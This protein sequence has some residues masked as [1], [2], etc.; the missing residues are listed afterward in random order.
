MI[1]ILADSSFLYLNP[2]STH[3]EV[4]GFANR[5]QEWSRASNSLDFNLVVSKK[6]NN[7][8]ADIEY[9]PD[10][11]SIS[12]CLAKYSIEYIDRRDL[13]KIITTLL[14]NNLLEDVIETNDYLADDHTCSVPANLISLGESQKSFICDCMRLLTL[15]E[16]ATNRNRRWCYFLQVPHLSL[17]QKIAHES[18]FTIIDSDNQILTSIPLPSRL[19]S[20]TIF[21]SELNNY[22][23]SIPI[24]I[25][26]QTP[27][28]LRVAT[29]IYIL[30]HYQYSLAEVESLPFTF[31]KKFFASLENNSVFLNKTERIEQILKTLSETILGQN[32]SKRHALREGSGPEDP[33]VVKNGEKAWRR[34][35]DY[36]FHLH[37]W[38][39]DGKIRFAKIG[40][41]NEFD[42]PY[43]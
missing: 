6:I 29:M 36:E 21:L 24:E 12:A 22:L 17:P 41:H 31:G 2:S 11:P 30:T 32:L 40:T 3:S 15:A 25:L 33:Q 38:E 1:G 28:K 4:D 14:T 26:W 9:Y 39:V 37:Y 27:T 18:N 7:H 43:E 34:D 5:I 8:F 20:Q 23:E 42:I 35:I 10:F 16:Y 13:L 19:E